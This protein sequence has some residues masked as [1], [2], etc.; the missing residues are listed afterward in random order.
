MDGTG[1]I[2]LEHEAKAAARAAQL[3][4][5][6]DRRPG[7]TRERDGEGFVYR[8]PDGRPVCEEEVLTRIRKLA[9]PPAWD[10][11][12][13]CPEPNG[14]IQ[15]VGRDARR[16]K[17]YRYHARWREVRDGAKFERIV[18]FARKLPVIRARVAADL[19]RPGLPR[20]KVLATVVQLLE[21]TLIRVGNDEYAKSNGSYGLTTLRN[22]H[23]RVDGATVIFNF[24]GKSG[25]KHRIDLEDELLADI[26]R[27]CQELPGQDLF[28]YLGEDGEVRSIGSSDV[29][30]YLHEIAGED[31]TAKDFRTWAATTLAAV[32]LAR[33]EDAE[34]KKAQKATIRLAIEAVADILGNTPAICRKCYVH[35]AVIEGYLARTLKPVMRAAENEPCALWRDGLRPEEAAVVTFLES[36]AARPVRRARRATR[37]AALPRQQDHRAR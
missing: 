12:W 8:Y 29:N 3:R 33:F 15:A 30:E 14:H 32:A 9:I 25:V 10:E 28:T 17:Q 19:A 16:R 37:R 36:A 13:I 4:Y 26:V 18:G 6:S 11:V 27:R 21:R 22:R 23:A 5:V 20:E 1:V 24:K 31:V 34:T 2:R 35:P 7:I